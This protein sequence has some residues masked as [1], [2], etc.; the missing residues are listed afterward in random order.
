MLSTML[1]VS[2]V[3]L[4]V[5]GLLFAAG[6]SNF[7]SRLLGIVCLLIAIGNINVLVLN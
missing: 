6:G 5:M 4:A 2:T 1:I 7:Q 3:A